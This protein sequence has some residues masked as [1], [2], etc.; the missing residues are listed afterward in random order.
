MRRPH[1]AAHRVIWP[2][3]GLVVALGL[4][5]A[6]AWRPDNPLESQPIVAKAAP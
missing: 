1:R 5:L 4:A 2:V 6:L 3:L